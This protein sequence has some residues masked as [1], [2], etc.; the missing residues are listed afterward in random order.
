MILLN[1]HVFIKKIIYPRD[2]HQGSVTRM[3]ELLKLLIKYPE[4][5]WN[6]RL[7]SK[8]PRTTMEFIEKHPDKPWNWG[9]VSWNKFEKY[10]GVYRDL[11]CYDNLPFVKKRREIITRLL[12]PTILPDDVIRHE[13]SMFL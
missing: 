6:W 9:C 5:P 2:R 3:N 1:V 11:K 12:E 4:K 13:I 8:N 10:F 7:I